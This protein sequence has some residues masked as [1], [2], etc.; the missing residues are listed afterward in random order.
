LPTACTKQSGPSTVYFTPLAPTRSTASMDWSDTFGMSMPP[1]SMPLACPPTSNPLA[2]SSSGCARRTSD[3]RRLTPMPRAP[4]L[5]LLWPG[6]TRPAQTGT[7]LD[8]Q[9]VRDLE[10]ENTLAA[11]TNNRLERSSIREV[12]LT[13]CTDPAVIAYRQDILDDLW[14]HPHF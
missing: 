6:G 13:L 9:C 7:A 12:F 2:K 5:S 3:G 10:L 14:C 11:L 1:C 4:S 8:P